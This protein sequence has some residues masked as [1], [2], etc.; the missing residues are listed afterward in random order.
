VEKEAREEHLATHG[1]NGDVTLTVP[2]LSTC[3]EEEDEDEEGK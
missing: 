1:L 3:E 2:L